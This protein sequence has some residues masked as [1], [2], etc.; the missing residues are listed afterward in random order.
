MQHA[1]RNSGAQDVQIAHGKGGGTSPAGS[2]MCEALA[3]R[4]PQR[5]LLLHRCAT[6]CMPEAGLRTH[7]VGDEVEE[8]EVVV[9]GIQSLANSVAV[10]WVMPSFLNSSIKLC[11]SCSGRVEEALPIAA[12][13]GASRV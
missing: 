5:A 12:S 2:S 9:G 10:G 8:D 3:K 1:A 7:V 4:H 13:K 6:W 11:L